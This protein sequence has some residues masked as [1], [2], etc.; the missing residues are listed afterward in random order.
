M[1]LHALGYRVRGRE[2][3]ETRSFELI[4]I[5]FA[6]QLS[7]ITRSG[8][9][10]ARNGVIRPSR[11]REMESSKARRSIGRTNFAPADEFFAFPLTSSPI[12]PARHASH[13]PREP[14]T[15]GAASSLSRA[16]YL[17]RGDSAVEPPPGRIVSSGPLARGYLSTAMS[18]RLNIP[19]RHARPSL[20][21]PVT[22]F[23]RPLA[24]SAFDAYTTPSRRSARLL[25]T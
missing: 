20:S 4:M 9:K 6:R 16:I 15:Q 22:T 7:Q 3:N 23:G 21:A 8:P 2:L 19:R 14:F 13:A 5:P 11:H 17:A 18:A 12:C 25:V 10:V 24:C 1:S